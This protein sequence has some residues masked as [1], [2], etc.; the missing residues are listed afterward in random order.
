M[1]APLK[2]TLRHSDPSISLEEEI[3]RCTDKLAKIAPRLTRCE[4]LV[5]SP[6]HHH[7]NGAS[8]RVRIDLAV[9]GRE[10]VVDRE[11]GPDPYLAVRKAFEIAT[12]RLSA[13]RRRTLARHS[14]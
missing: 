10:I 2:I 4:V 8:W 3:L 6:S 7:R 12:R 13:H 14:H 9:P 1:T 5:D 11:P